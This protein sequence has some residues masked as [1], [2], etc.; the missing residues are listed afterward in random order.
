[1]IKTVILVLTLLAP[2]AAIAQQSAKDV[3]DDMR[4]LQAEIAPQLPMQ[5]DY[6]TQLIGFYVFMSSGVCRI[7]YNYLVN[8]ERHIDNVLEYEKANPSGYAA[9]SRDDVV[10][11]IA[12]GGNGRPIFKENVTEQMRNGMPELFA[13]RSVIISMKYDFDDNRV[14]SIF[15]NSR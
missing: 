14:A 15:I 10:A 12:I 9:P 2:W 5:I 6:M 7:N 13:I 8:T 4:S 1:M 3:C 11:D